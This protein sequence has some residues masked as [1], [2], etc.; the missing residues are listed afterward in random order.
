[1]S[2]FGQPGASGRPQRAAAD[3]CGRTPDDATGSAVH[4][5]CMSADQEQYDA[6]LDRASAHA[7]RWLAAAAR[8]PGAAAGRRRRAGRTVLGGDLP[9][10]PTDPAEVVDLLAAARRAG[11]DGDAVRPV[12][13]LGDRRHA[14]GRAGRR[15]A[16][17]RLGPERRHAA[18]P[19]RRR[20]PPRRPPRGW[21]LDLLG[22]PA[23]ADVGF[24]TG[25]T[26][27]NFTGLAAG[28]QQRAAARPAGT[29]TGAA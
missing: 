26:M 28:R 19:P 9:D 22:L 24:V 12:L 2:E 21:L 27:A 25:A 3:A 7:R 16:G 14:A 29:S 1:M 10:G 13:R 5:G 6:A 4:S 18:T 23:G 20:P 11:A 8:P 15:L 17:Q